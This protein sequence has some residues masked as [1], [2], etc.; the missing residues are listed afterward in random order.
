M[1][2]DSL[3]VTKLDVLDD[4]ETIRIC[5]GYKNNGKLYNTF[6]A[7]IEILNNCEPI[8]EEVSGWCED[9]SK[10]R[11]AK[12]LPEKARNYIKTIENIIGVKVKMISVG[13]ERS[14]II[15]N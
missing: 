13:P 7:D 1:D 3:I 6:P 8:Y 14:Q 11:S 15:N 4:Q 2:V 5:T 9:T 12:N 10:V